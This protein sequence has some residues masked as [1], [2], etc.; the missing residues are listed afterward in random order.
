MVD[1]SFLGFL[2]MVFALGVLAGISIP[3]RKWT[4]IHEDKLIDNEGVVIGRWYVLQD[5][6]G[7]IKQRKLR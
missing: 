5:Q 7:R 1:A 2:P 6:N 3:K 4:V